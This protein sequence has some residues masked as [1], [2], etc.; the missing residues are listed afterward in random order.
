MRNDVW[1]FRPIITPS[2]TAVMFAEGSDKRI[3]ATIGTTTTAISIKSR[4][5]PSIKITAI[6]IINFA[7]K[8]PG[9]EFRNSRT[10]S[11]PPNALN[12]AVSTAAPSNIIKTSEV[13]FAVSSITSFKVFSILKRRR[14]LQIRDIIKIV[15]PIIP[16]KMPVKSLASSINRI[17]ISKFESAKAIMRIEINKSIAGRYAV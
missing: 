14:E 3:G 12:A 17:F 4:K 8:P 16:I 10:K 2:Q 13:V 1:M 5:N 15:A 7:Q 6:T 11:S 9:S